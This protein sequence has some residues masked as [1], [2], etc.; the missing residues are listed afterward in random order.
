MIIQIFI[1]EILKQVEED[2]K[3]KL[4]DPKVAKDLLSQPLRYNVWFLLSIKN[5]FLMIYLM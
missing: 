5:N 1:L 3:V 2:G 4:M